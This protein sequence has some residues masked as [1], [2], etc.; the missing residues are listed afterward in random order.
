MD[1]KKR[2]KNFEERFQKELK[3]VRFGYL[4]VLNDW[5]KKN[6]GIE[7]NSNKKRFKYYVK[8]KCDCLNERFISLEYILKKE[9]PSC[10][11]T[12]YRTKHGACSNGNRT[13]LYKKYQDMVGRCYCSTHSG[14]EYYGKRGIQV[15]DEWKNNFENFKNWALNNGYEDGLTIERLDVNS[16]Y[17][18][19]NCTWIPMKEQHL[20]KRK[21]FTKLQ[22][23]KNGAV[24]GIRK[25]K[26]SYYVRIH[27]NNKEVHVGTAKTYE[28]AAQMRMEAEEKY[29]DTK[30]LDRN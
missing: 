14:W 18:P 3:G 24:P 15:C 27:V 30:Y 11:C 8:V 13:A 6:H 21:P 26:Q 4:R 7:R 9:K 23:V 2:Y 10:G 16:D 29:W 5:Y 19:S 1:K 17:K 28:D 22:D 12:K 20:N 25:A